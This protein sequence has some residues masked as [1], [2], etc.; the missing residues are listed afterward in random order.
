MKLKTL[1]LLTIK[2]IFLL[3]MLL[4]D[5]A[6]SNTIYKDNSNEKNKID[7]NY[8]RNL[9]S[10]ESYI[11]GTGDIINLKVYSGDILA[12]EET[13]NIDGEGLANLT[14]LKKIFIKGLTIQELTNILNEEYKSYVKDPD[15]TL[16]IEKYRPL[17][18]Y[19]DGEVENPGMYVL[20]GSASPLEFVE[21]SDNQETVFPSV[22]DVIR[23][24]NGITV[25]ADLGNIEITRINSISNGGGRIKTEINLLNALN[26]Q[27]ISQN[28]RL[29]DNDTIMIPRTDTPATKQISKAIKSNLNPSFI[30]I[31]IGGNV[32]T[33]GV[34]KVSK[35]STLN[36]ALIIGGGTT[37]LKGPAVFLR[38][39]NNGDIDRRKFRLNNS[40]ERGSFVNPFLK[41]GDVIFLDRSKFS[42]ATEVLGE[43][44]APFQGIFSTWGFF[45]LIF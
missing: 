38:Y 30:N 10:I 12:I 16:E 13:F 42:V 24:S 45:K 43:V 5:L 4:P 11:L 21:N 28:I 26:L 17:R 39:L 36:E 29:F 1:K 18:L 9:P 8:I 14:R 27:D 2:S 25:Y 15:V 44:T 31:F 19:I 35:T 22:F 20:P 6:Y 41:D 34:V 37:V 32:N 7:S 23:K 3:S 33:P 40:A